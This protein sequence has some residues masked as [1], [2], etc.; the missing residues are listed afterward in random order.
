[1]NAIGVKACALPAIIMTIHSTTK[2]VLFKSSSRS[3]YPK[4]GA[5]VLCLRRDKK[6][7]LREPFPPLDASSVA[8]SLIRVRV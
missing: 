7:H 6:V 8:L 2:A 1:M 5:M 3:R 4:S